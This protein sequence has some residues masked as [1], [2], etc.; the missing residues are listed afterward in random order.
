MAPTMRFVLHP[1][2]QLIALSLFVSSVCAWGAIGH[3]IVA[4]IAQTQLHPAVREHLCTILPINQTGY[5][6]N[7]PRDQGPQKHCHL[8]PLAGWPDRVRFLYPWSSHLHYVNPVDD[9]PPKHCTYGENGWQDKGTGNVLEALVNYT[10]RVAL[11][12]GGDRDVALRF[13]THY[14]GDA[15]QPLHLTGRARGGN[16][17]SVRFEGRYAKLHTVWDSLLINAQIRQL[18]NYTTKLS[19]SRIESALVG[20]PYDAYIRWILV[21]GLGQGGKTKGHGNDSSW[22]ADEESEWTSCPDKLINLAPPKHSRKR[23]SRPA[24]WLR[25][26]TPQTSKLAQR[27]YSST[28]SKV[29]SSVDQWRPEEVDDTDLPICPFA[30]TK[31]MHPLVCSYAFAEPVPPPGQEHSGPLAELDVPEYK[32][33]IEEHKVIQ[34]Q[35]AKA[36]IR[37]AAVINTL[38]LPEALLAR[39]QDST[40]F[41]HVEMVKESREVDERGTATVLKGRHSGKSSQPPILGLIKVTASS[42]AEVII[43][44]SVGYILARKGILDKK[45]QTK[46]NKLN[47]SFFTPALLFS[48]VAFTLNPARLAEL[49]I[50]PAGFVIIT[51][52]STLAA[53]LLSSVTKLSKSQ[54]NFS[55]ACAMTPNSNSLPV[56]LMQSLVVTVPQLHWEE[57]GEPEDTVNGMLGRALTY[58]VLFSTLGMFLRWSVA[59][60]LLST[61]DEEDGPAEEVDEVQTGQLIDYV[62]EPTTAPLKLE[63]NVKISIRRSTEDG[64]GMEAVGPVALTGEDASQGEH[65]GRRHSKSRQGPPAWARSFP[66]SPR[67]S[68]GSSLDEDDENES[69]DSISGRGPNTN[70]QRKSRFASFIRIYHVG[71]KRPFKAVTSFMTMPLYAAVISLVVALIPPLQKLIGSI[72]PLVGALET[73]GACSIPLTMVVLGAYFYQETD[74]VNTPTDAIMTATSEDRDRWTDSANGTLVVNGKSQQKGKSAPWMRNPWNRSSNSSDIGSEAG[75]SHGGEDGEAASTLTTQANTPSSSSSSWFK[76]RRPSQMTPFERREKKKVTMERRTIF[77]AVASRMIVTPLVLLPFLAYYALRTEGDVMDDPVFKTCACLLIG[78]PPALTL[79][80]I[81][82]QSAKGSNSSFEK[83]ISKTI[84][85]SYAILAAPTTIA[86]VTVALIISEKDGY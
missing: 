40:Q 66:N 48:K 19:S 23:A 59:S 55:I 30:W 17:I 81:T 76:G 42:I 38:L 65:I 33:R 68:R 63:N 25:T 74:P 32:G 10:S 3:E 61:M 4:T 58:L 41:S 11:S 14:M 70:V 56:A 71:I 28:F 34:K 79:A 54:R 64:G 31:S 15:H 46:I 49:I 83:L 77:V 73:A 12:K 78:S 53:L 20:K 5:I 43:L 8:G 86:L 21:E 57:E 35:L 67:D 75:F 39:G 44:S 72:E 85:V 45:T 29:P 16:D 62:Q 13:L 37:L 60:Q 82:S 2:L 26:V 69:D 1:A 6:S 84:F 27:I 52:V 50:V 51:V 7:Y 18:A 36:G 24:H 9:E 22:W 80:Q 47:V